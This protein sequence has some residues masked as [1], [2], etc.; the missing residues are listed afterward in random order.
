MANFSKKTNRQEIIVVTL[1]YFIFFIIGILSYQDFGISVDEWDLRVLGF[2]NLKYIT[3]IFFQ[4]ISVKLDE[5]LLIPKIS[6]Y[7]GNTHGAIFA[8][9]MAFV[10]YF[11][12]ITDSQKYY[13]IRHYFNHLIFLI[14]NFYFFLLVKERFN[15]WIYGIFGGLFLFLSPRIFAE[16]FYNQKDILFL[17]LFTINLYYGIHFLKSPSL[18]NSILFSFTTALAID[19]RIMGIIIVPIIIFLTYLKYLRNK[20]F[21]IFTGIS[22]YLILFPLLTILF[23][24]YLWENPFTHFAQV[25]KILSSFPLGGYNF[26]LGDYYETSNLPWHYI[27]VWIG[28]TTPVFYLVLFILGFSNYTLRLK[29]RISKIA[30]NNSLN[31]FWRGEAELQDLIYYVLFIIPIFTVILLNSTL[32]NGWRHL[33]FVYPCFLLI[34]LKG[35]YLIDLYY[36][37][38]KNWQLKIFVALFLTHIAFIMIKDHPHQ[39]VYFNFL[40][41]KNIQTKFELDYWGLSNKQ[42][43]EYIL[44]NDSKNV[45]RIGSAGP[46][47][48]ENSKQ[49]LSSLEKNRISI[50][51]NLE[52]D[53][54]ID[55]YINWYGAYKKKRH[56]IPNNFKIYKEI[57]VSGKRIISIYKRI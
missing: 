4:N 55:N 47:S 52:S 22:I 41:G 10:E 48:I 40:A 21:K 1:I 30:N 11:F 49:I 8:L 42:A 53:Y 7:S 19:I 6:D 29:K 38:K 31:N 44:K 12:N 28:I 25:F 32:Y 37:R 35:L 27:F 15:N 23:W 45:I 9:P 18:K 2:V 33:Y 34:S 17:S 3:E 36:L 39:N 14:S 57:F 24:P 13:F 5:I 26:Y 20:N 54:I 16:S 43:L 51:K 56:E 50:S 46:I